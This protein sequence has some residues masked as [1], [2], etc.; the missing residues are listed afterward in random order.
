MPA[1]P[2]PPSQGQRDIGTKGQT[3]E[4]EADGDDDGAASDEPAPHWTDQLAD[5]VRVADVIDLDR[6]IEEECGLSPSDLAPPE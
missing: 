2:T 5:T 4:G 3:D 6:I 1:S